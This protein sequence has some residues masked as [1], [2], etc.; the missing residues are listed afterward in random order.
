MKR[1]EVNQL[2]AEAETC[3]R[4]NGWVLPPEP[5][6]DV[7]DFG[8]GDHRRH[9]LVL[10]NLAVEPEYCEKLMYAQEGMITPCHC[11]A[12]KKED[13]ICRSG[14]FVI[15]LWPGRPEK[16][17]D[18]PFTVRIDGKPVAAFGGQS[19]PIAAGSRITIERGM[20]HAFW[21]VSAECVIGEVSTAN[22][23]D[24]DNYF[25]DPN[26]GRFPPIEEDAEPRYRLIGDRA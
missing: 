22:D 16:A 17:Q 19:I 18:H 8:L 20:F 2:L 21:P 13:I 9:G 26:V 10:I 12:R 5:Q 15:Q 14:A 24:N 11:H 23:D 6:W 25:A 7:T 3:F 4:A 1:S